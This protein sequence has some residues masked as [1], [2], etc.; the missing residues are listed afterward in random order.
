[1]AVRPVVPLHEDRVDVRGDRGGFQSPI[2]GLSGSEYL[3]NVDSDHLAVATVFVQEGVDEVGR[4]RED[5]VGEPSPIA[6]AKSRR[7]GLRMQARLLQVARDRILAV[8]GQP[9]RP[10]KG[11][12]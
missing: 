11:G 2:E 1:M 5:R 12:D 3:T 4:R 10:G 9:K 6:L 7:L 8:A